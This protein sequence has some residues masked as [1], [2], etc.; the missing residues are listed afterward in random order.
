MYKFIWN[1]GNDRVKRQFMCNDFS[2]CGLKMIDPYS[3]AI[4]QKMFW[5]KM[6]LDDNYISLWKS[7]ELAVLV[8]FNKEKNILWKARDP[9]QIPNKL[10]SSQLAD[11][12]ERGT[13]LEKTL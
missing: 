8:K 2:L 5:V 9:D 7:I 11:S 10:Y 12:F 13:F 3:Y 4:A 6:L 1:G